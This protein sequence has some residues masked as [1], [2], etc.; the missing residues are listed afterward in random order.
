[1]S[2]P[3]QGSRVAGAEWLRQ[4]HFDTKR[5]NWIC[6]E[7][8][9]NAGLCQR[10]SD[11]DRGER[12]IRDYQL[13]KNKGSGWSFRH[14]AAFQSNRR[15]QRIKGKYGS[16]DQDRRFWHRSSHEWDTQARL[17]R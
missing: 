15:W 14:S 16:S 11:H 17:V 5:R 7:R 8:M 9:T 2:D 3:H 4:E 12:S 13:R 1:M 10:P 6:F